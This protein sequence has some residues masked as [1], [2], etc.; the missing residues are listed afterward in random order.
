MTTVVFYISGH[1]F[2]HA[3]R[4]V[5][6]MN[7]LGA[8]LGPDLRL[9]IRSAVSPSLLE[10]TLNVPYE[11]RPGI[12]DTGIIQ[13]NSVT[14]DDAATVAAASAFYAEFDQRADAEAAALRSDDVRGKDAANKTHR[15]VG[16]KVRQTIKELG[17][18]MPEELPP[19]E[20]IKKLEKGRAKLEAPTPKKKRG[21][22]GNDGAAA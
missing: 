3:S 13:S 9:I 20:S 5:E 22:G 19:A 4:E 15:D 10:R 21:K 14:H 6:V 7:A 18:T 16:A 1:G 12:C 8:R 17:G 2:G 11:L